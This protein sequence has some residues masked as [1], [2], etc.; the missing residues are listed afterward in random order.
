MSVVTW[1]SPCDA[2]FAA[3]GFE[4]RRGTVSPRYNCPYF[5]IYHSS[6]CLNETSFLLTTHCNFSV[7]N[8]KLGV[9]TNYPLAWM[10]FF[11]T[12][13][14]AFPTSYCMKTV[15]SCWVWKLDNDACSLNLVPSASFLMQS[16]RLEKKVYQSLSVRK[17]ALRTR[18]MLTKTM[19]RHYIISNV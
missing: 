19:V 18:L 6:I 14:T 1:A 11:C 8:F 7:L 16:D 13:A 10:F 15:C 4:G 5:A 12:L 2:K 3:E 17:E 9:Q